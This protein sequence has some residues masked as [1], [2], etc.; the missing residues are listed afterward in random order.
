[1]VPTRPAGPPRA[2]PYNGRVTPTAHEIV[3]FGRPGCHLCEDAHEMIVELLAARAAAGLAAPTLVERS[4]EDD[5]ELLR[6][7]LLV[8]PVVAVGGRELELAT[9]RGSLRRFL[10]DALDGALAGGGAA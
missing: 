8:I 10:D 1:M 9:S 7:Y 3:L 6:R 4:I 2:R 5:D